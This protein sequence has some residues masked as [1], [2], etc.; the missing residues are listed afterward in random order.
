MKTNN[1]IWNNVIKQQRTIINRAT[2]LFKSW[3][4]AKDFKT[5]SSPSYQYTFCNKWSK[6]SLEKFKCNVDASFSPLNNKVGIALCIGDEHG[7][8]VLTK[9]EQFSPICDVRVDKTL[10][11]LLT[12]ILGS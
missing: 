12:L 3:Q 6:P 11:L 10:C 9:I 5:T 1:K 8:F 7:V 2:E 4:A